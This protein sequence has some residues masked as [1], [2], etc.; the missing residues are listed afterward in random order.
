MTPSNVAASKTITQSSALPILIL[1][2]SGFVLVTT[3]FL[4]IGLIP[5]LSRNLGISTTEA[6]WL[7]SLFAFTV[8]ICGPFLTA[9]LAHVD[10]K[11]L[12]AVILLIFAG[13]N[14]LAA[15]SPNVWV[16]ALARFIPALALPVFWGTASE[17]AA[18]IDIRTTSCWSGGWSRL[19]RHLCGTGVWRT[20]SHR[21]GDVRR[22]A[23]IIR[24][25][26]RPVAVVA[27]DLALYAEPAGFAERRA[28]PWSVRHSQVSALSAS[29]R[30]IHRAVHGDVHRLHLF[31]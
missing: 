9:R 24:H 11:S 28:G 6:G 18:Q 30:P 17:T 22:L 12:F 14:L 25:S 31:G 16:L 21:R 4:I 19:S 8:M 20:A 7:V 5:P 27:D 3:E 10:R 15:V 29:C 2:L 13:A 26:R 23:R 1:A